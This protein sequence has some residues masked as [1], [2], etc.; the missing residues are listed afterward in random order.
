MRRGTR[1]CITLQ[2]TEIGN[3]DVALFNLNNARFCL[4]L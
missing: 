1:T 4:G 2:R 3:L